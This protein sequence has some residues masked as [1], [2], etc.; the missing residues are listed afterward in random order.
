MVN[1]RANIWALGE[2]GVTRIIS[3]CAVGSLR[4]EIE[5]G[6]VVV[7][8]QLIDRTSGRVQTFHDGPKTVHLPWAQ[9]FCQVLRPLAAKSVRTAGL[10]VHE[11]GTIVVIQGPRFSTKAE[12]KWYAAAGG[13][14]VNMTQYPE[15]YLARELGICFVNLSLVTDY[16]SG[17]SDE[18]VSMDE[19]FAFFTSKLD[20]LRVAISTLVAAIPDATPDCCAT[21]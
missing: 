6:D 9:P 8:D 2:S 10:S 5:P 11:N 1:Y 3:P 13:D 14:V 21:G 15:S 16:D 20:A 4:R 12:S 7:C 19:I 18:S 17:V